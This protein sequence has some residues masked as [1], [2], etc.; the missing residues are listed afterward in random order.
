M[1]DM[2]ILFGKK[3]P[4]EPKE[5]I[6]IGV[7]FEEEI[8]FKVLIGNDGIWNTIKNFNNKKSC[9]WTPKNEGEYIVMVQGKRKGSKKP[10]E[11]LA[12]EEYIIGKSLGEEKLIKE[13]LLDKEEC[14]TGEKVNIEVVSSKE[15]L[16][17]RFWRRGD[18][19]WEPV[20]DYSTDNKL[21][22]AAVREGTEEVLIECKKT[23]SKENVDEYKTVKF[24]V[25]E[26]NKVEITDFKCLT[27]ELLLNEELVF[28]V[29]ASCDDARPL[30]FKFVRVDK[31]GRSV[32]IQDFSSRRIVS[33]QENEEGE[34]KLLCLMKDIFSNKEYDD[35]AVMLYEVRPYNAVRINS[36]K[37]DVK[38]PQVSGT[39]ITFKADAYG[40][41][42]LVYRYIVDGPIAEDSCYTRSKEFYWNPRER[43][44]YKI[45]LYVKD[46]SYNG[47]YEDKKTI[48]F[49]IDKKGDKP[50]R[51]V[52]VISDQRKEVLVNRPINVR[53]IAEGGTI[54]LYSFI[55]F[56]DGKEIDRIDYSRTNWLNYTPK[57]KGEYEISI[58]VK[59]K[60]SLEDYD[61]DSSVFLKVK[62]YLPG[63][64]DYILLP[65][66]ELFLVGDE[67]EVEAVVQNTKNIL[68]NFVTKINGHE[69]EETG[70]MKNKKIVVKPK[71]A[72]KYT[73]EVYAKNV[74]C[75]GEF[76]TK[77]DINIYV[78]EAIPVTGTKIKIDKEPIKIN[79]EVNFWAESVG[80][81]DVCYEFYLMEKGNWVKAQSYSKKRYYTFIP[82]SK[83]K[84][85]V[86]VLAKSFYKR[87]NYEDYCEIEFTV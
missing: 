14:F 43:G 69:V 25:K 60:Y 19:G 5:N 51:I 71:C 66:R 13:I 41:R 12:K 46:I 83:G 75:E 39:D 78:H 47:D 82:F 17:Y 77:R 35:R 21:S 59:D 57:E 68:I 38:T 44:S 2:N 81:K 6:E 50:I 24:K 26:K 34:Y 7:E 87:V 62:D 10:F 29:K 74:K 20:R 22:Y 8:D 63:N 3:S 37:A 1:G 80:G 15:V 4:Q 31:Y 40:G 55:I 84:Y 64:I 11:F 85:R 36:F 54:L 45:T 9:V 65:C 18:N 73:F 28:K 67:I 27:D 53:A 58:R 79:T 30:L 52:D 33:F 32:C 16:L 76:D 23:N 61:V 70:F 56:R 86:M 48:L 49:D 42:E 72:G